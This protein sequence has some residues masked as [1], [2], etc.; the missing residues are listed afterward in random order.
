MS[1]TNQKP[2]MSLNER[3]NLLRL[4]WSEEDD[5]CDLI[6]TAALTSLAAADDSSDVKAAKDALRKSIFGALWSAAEHAVKDAFEMTGAD[7]GPRPLSQREHAIMACKVLSHMI[8]NDR[9]NMVDVKAAFGA[10]KATVG[11]AEDARLAL[12][13]AI[14]A[15]EVPEPGFFSGVCQDC[16]DCADK[17][18]NRHR[19]M[20]DIVKEHVAVEEIDRVW[21]LREAQDVAMKGAA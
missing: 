3:I 5:A 18:V 17:A 1:N 6:N 11:R 8:D 13:W 9:A 19:S 2:V 12:E 21:R 4:K 20:I 7:D 10:I 15:H 16:I 14:Y